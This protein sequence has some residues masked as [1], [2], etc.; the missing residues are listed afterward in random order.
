MVDTKV[1]I[2]SNRSPRRPYQ[3]GAITL[4]KAVHKGFRFAA[5]SGSLPRPVTKVSQDPVNPPIVI[6]TGGCSKS[7]ASPYLELQRTNK[8]T[9][10]LAIYDEKVPD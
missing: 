5:D 8:R 2:D 4:Y 9:N 1:G 3:K 10:H 6:R 7:G